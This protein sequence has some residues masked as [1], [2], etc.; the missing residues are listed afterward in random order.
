MERVHLLSW[1][2]RSC[3]LQ[4]SVPDALRSCRHSALSHRGLGFAH[5]TGDSWHLMLSCQLCLLSF[6]FSWSVTYFF[7][8]TMGSQSKRLKF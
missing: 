2:P 7:I 5:F 6:V 8:V 3:H 4:T 1:E